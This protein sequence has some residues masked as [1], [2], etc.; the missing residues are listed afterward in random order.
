MSVFGSLMR[1]IFGGAQGVDAYEAKTLIDANPDLVIID[2][3]QAGEFRG[4]HLANA[5]HVPVGLVPQRA[6]HM[7]KEAPYL[8]YCLSGVRSSRAAAALTRAGAKRVYKL[9]GGILAW[10][11]A[12]FGV[13]KK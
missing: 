8:V 6:R 7:E 9:N 3:R 13:E 12:G 10:Q 5:R 11:A 1:R 2:V 4:G